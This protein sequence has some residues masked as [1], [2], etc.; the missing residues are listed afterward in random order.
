MPSSGT[1][2]LNCDMGESF[3]VWTLGQ[4]EAVMPF[5]DQANLACGFHAGDPLS[6]QCSVALAVEHGVRIGAHPA[7]PDLVGFGR[8]HLSCSPAEV[9]AL[10]LYQIGALDAF[11]RAAGTEVAY[12][13]PHGALYNDLVSDDA[14]LKA[15]LEACAA[16]RSGLPLMV[17]AQIDNRRERKLAEALGVPLLFEAFADRAYQADGHLLS[18]RLPGAVHHD[19]QRILSQ[20]LA[21]ARGQSFPDCH[22]NRLHLKADSLCVHGDNPEALEVLRRLRLALDGRPA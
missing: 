6:I 14:L 3:G 19:S 21:I 7:Y 15:V 5:I 11:C 10:V 18:R 8:R 17:L 22:G 12:V 13:K 2:L 16:Y 1:I 9:Q 20:A 4:D